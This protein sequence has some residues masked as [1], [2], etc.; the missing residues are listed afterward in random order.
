MDRSSSAA[1]HRDSLRLAVGQRIRRLMVSIGLLLGISIVGVVGTA[2]PASAQLN[3]GMSS[4]V[5]P[6]TI[7]V[8]GQVVGWVVVVSCD[9]T[10]PPRGYAAGTEY[11]TWTSGAPWRGAFILVPTTTVPRH[12]TYTWQTFPHEHFDLSRTVLFPPVSPAEHDEFYRVQVASG[13]GWKE[14]GYM[15][16]DVGSSTAPIVPT[17]QT[18]YGVGLTTDLVG[19]GGPI[20]FQ[21][22]TPPT[23]RSRNVYLLQ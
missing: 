12:S 11:W 13:T 2:A 8:N 1:R 21:T 15:W 9:N 5:A 23:P 22:G 10:A 14:Q 16:L 19:N 6:Y 7:Q 4:L 17:V 18:W 20:R 3:D